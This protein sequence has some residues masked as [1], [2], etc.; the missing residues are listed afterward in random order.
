[1]AK[2]IASGEDC[3]TEGLGDESEMEIHS[4]P[5]VFLYCWDLKKK[6]KHLHYCIFLK[7]CLKKCKKLCPYLHEG[8]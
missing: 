7:Q 4:L 5:C 3:Q 8:T 1:M 2:L 6:K